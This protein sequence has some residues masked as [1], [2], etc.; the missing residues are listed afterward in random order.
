MTEIG[1]ACVVA[2]KFTNDLSV[3]FQCNFPLGA[4]PADINAEL[5]K[6]AAVLE[7]QQDRIDVPAMERQLEQQ[8]LNLEKEAGM[9]AELRGKIDA[10]PNAAVRNSNIEQ[11]KTQEK[12][13]VA[14]YETMKENIKRAEAY[15]EGLKKKA[16]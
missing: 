12:Q 15:L 13:A 1:Y 10:G 9:I 7:R 14:T 2:R 11:M 4:P 3:S 5:D 16:A 8:R 6:L